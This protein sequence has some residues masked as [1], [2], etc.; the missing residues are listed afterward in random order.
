MPERM[1]ENERVTT[2]VTHPN[3]G[4]IWGGAFTFYAI[5]AVFGVL[6]VAIFGSAASPN[7]AHP[8][9]GMNI[10]ISVWSVILT[11]IAMYVAGRV[12]GHLAGIGNRRDGVVHGITMF[13]L[14]VIGVA[15][16]AVLEQGVVPARSRMQVRIARAY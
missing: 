8:V 15:L 16:L 2:M 5:W 14:S 1:F 9:T 10:G 7:A 11:I 13:G 4:A 6:G 12:T 3:W